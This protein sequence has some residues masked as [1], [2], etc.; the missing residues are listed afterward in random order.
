MYYMICTQSPVPMFRSMF[1]RKEGD[2]NPKHADF[3]LSMISGPWMDL[4]IL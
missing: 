1:T 2:G 4:G 3:A